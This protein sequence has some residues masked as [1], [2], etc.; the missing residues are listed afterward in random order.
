MPRFSCLSIV[1]IA[2]AILSELAP[3]QSDPSLIYYNT[4]NLHT[5]MLSPGGADWQSARAYSRTLGGYLASIND[6]GEQGF[7]NGK[8]STIPRFWI[9]LSDAALEGLFVWDS[10]E[11]LTYGNWCPGEPNNT[12]GIED[13]VEAANTGNGFCWNDLSSPYSGPNSAPTRALIEIADGERVNFDS[14]LPGCDVLPFPLGAPGYP[15]GVSWN[16]AGGL[17]HHNAY[18]TTLPN[19]HWPVNGTGYLIVEANGGIP[20]PLGGPFPRPAPPTVNEVRIPIPAGTKGVSYAWEFLTAEGP[21]E[22]TFNDGMSIAIVDVNGHLVQSMSYADT[23]WS[24]EPGVPGAVYCSIPPSTVFPVGIFGEQTT[25][26]VLQPLPYPA[27]LSI[28]CWNG[29]DNAMTSAVAV[30]AIQ[31]WGSDEFKLNLTAPTGP[32]SIRLQ[33]VNGVAGNSYVTAVTLTQGAFPFGWLFGL[34]IGP[35]VLLDQIALGAAVPRNPER[36]RRL[37]LP[38]RERR[39]FRHPGLR[40]EPAVHGARSVRRLVRQRVDPGVLPDAV[41][42]RARPDGPGVPIPLSNIQPKEIPSMN[43]VLSIF[44]LVLVACGSAAAQVSP[45][46]TLYNLH[47]QHTYLLSPPGLDWQTARAYAHSLGGYLVA[48]NGNDEQSFIASNYAG[49]QQPLWLGLNDAANEGVFVW[50]SGEP[51]NYTIWCGNEPNNFGGDEDH[52][53]IFAAAHRVRPMLERHPVALRGHRHPRRRAGSSSSPYGVRV[54]FDATP[55]DLR[56]HAR[57]RRRSARSRA[58]KASRGTAPARTRTGFPSS[59]SVAEF[60]MPVTGSKYLRLV[61]EG[62]GQFAGRRPLPA[63]RRRRIVNEVRIAI[64]PGTKGVSFAYDFITAEDFS[65]Q[66]RHGHRGRRCERQPGRAPR[67]SRRPRLELR[68]SSSR[69]ALLQRVSAASQLLHVGPST[70]AKYLP[71]LPYPAYLSIVAWNGD[72]NAVSSAVHLDAVQ[73]WGT[74]KLQ[75]SM[76]APFG[77]GRSASRTTRAFRTRPIGPR[78]RWPRARIRTAGCSASTSR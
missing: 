57:S 14:G 19:A 58:P 16:G 60:G 15:E 39:A 7:I 61:G 54:D 59:P 28:V 56:T 67:L 9:G 72:D 13:Y 31:F 27:Y 71:I 50:D 34:D 11:P 21:F 20:M 38:D 46:Q 52:V 18:V 8:Y 73:F 3:A 68:Q 69:P 48:I 45:V 63:S 65:L 74:D 70:V 30:D 49:L 25:S 37:E 75:L 36:E 29:G 66:R 26:Y 77:P 4:V 35:E 53:E 41:T 1:V 47:N 33:N 51:V 22:P 64:P 17:A 12:G 55:R 76:S 32:G 44:V 10:G 23:T 42:S 5:Y 78:S 2:L 43:R 62:H 6:G 24:K 40:G